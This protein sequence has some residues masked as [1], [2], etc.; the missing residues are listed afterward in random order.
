MRHVH[1]SHIIQTCNTLYP[2]PGLELCLNPI[3]SLY[4]LH[5]EYHFTVVPAFAIP[6]GS[7]EYVKKQIAGL[8]DVEGSV[9]SDVVSHHVDDV[10]RMSCHV[11]S[12]LVMMLMHKSI[13]R[14]IMSITMVYVN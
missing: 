1:I 13:S 5:V 8:P 14:F 10:M 6:I 11:T 7:I 9:V 12:C 3:W 2:A 4:T